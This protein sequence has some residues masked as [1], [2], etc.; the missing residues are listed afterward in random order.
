MLLLEDIDQWLSLMPEKE[1][2]RVFKA[3]SR[4]LSVN[5]LRSVMEYVAK[6]GD[7]LL[8]HRNMGLIKKYYVDLIRIHKVLY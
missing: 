5:E 8:I 7:L 2:L 1:R 3:L 4:Y 6:G